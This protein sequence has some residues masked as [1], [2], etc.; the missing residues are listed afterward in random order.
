MAQDVTPFS[1]QMA[2]F[3]KGML[4]SEVT[5]MLAE[6]VKAVRDT[7]KKGSL[8]LT[9]NV[10]MLNRRDENAM[11]ITPNIKSKLPVLER[12]DTIMYSTY[13]GALLRNDPDQ[14]S[15]DLREV[16]TQQTEVRD[17]PAS[18]ERQ[19]RQVGGTE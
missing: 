7:G 19:I 14:P 9:I 10:S 3:N 1:Q 17:A 15:L 11:K 18:P 16:Q 5:E 4:D 2:F 6:L 12:A 8:T 13:D